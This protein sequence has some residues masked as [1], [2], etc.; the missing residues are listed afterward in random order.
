MNA[1]ERS[2]ENRQKMIQERIG[3]RVIR[4]R[5]KILFERF[6]VGK[7][8]VSGSHHR[9]IAPIAPIA[10][11]ALGL[12]L[13]S[14]SSSRQLNRADSSL[15]DRFPDH[16]LEEILSS[17]PAYPS[18]LN[19]LYA[20]AQVALSSP[21]DKGRFTAKISYGRPDSMIVRIGFPLGIEGARV[22]VTPDS[23][24]VYD[25]IENVLYSGSPSR[26]AA[27][28]P[29]AMAGTQIMEIATGFYSPDALTDWSVS[30]DSTL[31]LL[32]SPDGTL[33]YTIDPTLWR[34]VGFRQQDLE[35]TILEQRWYMEFELIDGILIPRRMT[36]S[37]PPEDTRLAMAIRRL[38]VDP[39]QLTFGL[40]IKDDTERTYLGE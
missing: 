38:Q 36:M 27:V 21:S 9:S 17:L 2:S 37:R 23:A 16:S 35:G 18:E 6:F 12:I 22:L 4:T 28:L 15:P 7:Q 5:R 31:Y 10:V 14:C 25:R 32:H 33:R 11:L 3:P 19:R 34:V 26:I 20:E 29:G 30:A 1:K 24:Y 8:S 40:D 39:P 13:S